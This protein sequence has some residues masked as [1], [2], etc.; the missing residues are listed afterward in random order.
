MRWRRARKILNPTGIQYEITC[1]P[2]TFE[3]VKTAITEKEIPTITAELTKV[4]SSTVKVTGGDVK[5]VLALMEALEEHDDVLAVHA[6]FDIS[7]EEME[8]AAE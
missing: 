2:A 3:A 4:P 8:Q 5:Q 1:E 6:N 7:D